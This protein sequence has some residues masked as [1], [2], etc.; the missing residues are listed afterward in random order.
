MTGRSIACKIRALAAVLSI[1][2]AGCAAHEVRRVQ[3]M[4]APASYFTATVEPGDSVATLANRYQ[5][6]E[7]DLLAMNDIANPNQLSA[8]SKIR[9]PAYGS[10]RVHSEI[11]LA[12]K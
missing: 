9:I 2:L 8:G 5:V 1:L 3:L 6:K 10:L 7:D 4:P 11:A 12:E